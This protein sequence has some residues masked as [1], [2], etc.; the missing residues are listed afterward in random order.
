MVGGMSKSLENVPF[1]LAFQMLMPGTPA[2]PINVCC[3]EVIH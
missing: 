3:V 1:T 2:A